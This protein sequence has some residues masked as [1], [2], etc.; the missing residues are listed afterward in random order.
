M[1][2]DESRKTLKLWVRRKKTG[3]PLPVAEQELIAR[4]HAKDRSDMAHVLAGDGDKRAGD[5][6]GE[7][8]KSGEPGHRVSSEFSVRSS[9]FRIQEV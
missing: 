5:L 4:L 8:E 1:E 3:V 2:I 7:Y 6:F 9:E